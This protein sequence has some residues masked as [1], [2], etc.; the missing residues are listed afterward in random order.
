MNNDIEGSV[1]DTTE[2]SATVMATSTTPESIVNAA[3]NR[4]RPLQ[5]PPLQKVPTFKSAIDAGTR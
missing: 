2:T 5:L 4:N 1:T 3:V